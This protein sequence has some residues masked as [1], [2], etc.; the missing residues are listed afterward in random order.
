MGDTRKSQAPE[1]E[2]AETEVTTR[3]LTKAEL[4]SELIKKIQG[5]LAKDELK[6]TVGD[7]LRLLQL[8]QEME[9]EQPR[10]IR[11]S[12]INGDEKEHASEE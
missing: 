5:K 7:L 9:E 6:P 2:K 1:A 10:E 4:V 8:E 11:V 12:W 3:R